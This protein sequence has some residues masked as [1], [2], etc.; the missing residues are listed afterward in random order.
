[1]SPRRNTRQEENMEEIV[2]RCLQDALQDSSMLGRIANLVTEAV[3]AAVAELSAALKKN[4]EI[5]EGLKTALNDRDKKIERLE[6]HIDDLEQYQRRQCIRIFGMTEEEN[7]NT[8]EIAIEVAEKVGVKV[9]L[10]DIDRS[11]RVGRGQENGRPRPIIVK[12]VSY[13]KRSEVFRNKR[14]LKGSG[15]TI[16]EDLTRARYHLLREAI[17]KYGVTNVWTQDGTIIVKEGNSKKRLRS[18]SDL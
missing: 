15:I 6:E 16:R 4:N 11:H 7:E 3:T 17:N 13:R 5:I 12:F 8:D 1:M 2:K 10:T 14:N 9:E 18:I